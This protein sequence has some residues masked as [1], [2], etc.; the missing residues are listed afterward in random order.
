MH[1]FLSGF[2][3]FE[4]LLHDIEDRKKQERKTAAGITTVHSFEGCE[5]LNI[6]H[7]YHTIEI[8]TDEY[9]FCILNETVSVY[10]KEGKF[11]FECNKLQYCKQGRFLVGKKK[12]I[13]ILGSKEEKEFGYA[14]YHDDQ[15]L[16]EPIFRATTWDE[17]FNLS[18]F[19][20]FRFHA[21]DGSCVMDKQGKI[22]LQTESYTSL[23]LYEAI[24]L[25]SKHYINLFTGETIC[26]KG[27]SFTMST[28]ELLFVQVDTNCIFQINIFKGDYIIHGELP[29]EKAPT[30]PYKAPVVRNTEPKAQTPHRNDPCPCGSSKKYKNCC[31]NKPA[32]IEGK[33]P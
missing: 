16:T 17:K 1:T 6:P 23:Y 14:L 32:N 10:N 18:G 26:K 24:C 12:P 2:P 20:I 8:G 4:Y 25:Y 27:Y 13:V 22:L 9:Y 29:A 31:M 11:C 28:K 7:K 5:R 3:F 19:G 30:P 15:K 21:K 33:Q